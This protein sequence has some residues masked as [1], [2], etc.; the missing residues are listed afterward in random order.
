MEIVI[1]PPTLSAMTV[2]EQEAEQLT[3]Q[4]ELPAI[5]LRLPPWQRELLTAAAERKG[6]SRQVLLQAAIAPIIREEQRLR[7]LEI[8]AEA[9]KLTKK[10]AY[11]T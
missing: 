7:D 3:H 8:T 9:E 11:P 4:R 2:Q 1:A 5:L 10:A 6:I